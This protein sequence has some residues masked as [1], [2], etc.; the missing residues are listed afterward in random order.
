MLKHK[1]YKTY[2]LKTQ[3]IPKLKY[4]LYFLI[5]YLLFIYF[6]YKLPVVVVLFT[7][8]FIL[9]KFILLFGFEFL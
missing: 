1:V 5:I 3:K 4:K 7:K 6:Y 2:F 8:G 9:F